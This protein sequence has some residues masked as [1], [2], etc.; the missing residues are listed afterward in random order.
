MQGDRLTWGATCQTIQTADSLQYSNSQAKRASREVAV[1]ESSDPRLPRSGLQ[2]KPGL[3][4]R[5]SSERAQVRDSDSSCVQGSRLED[6]P[7]PDRSSGAPD[8]EA[9]QAPS[10]AAEE[11]LS[12]LLLTHEYFR[13]ELLKSRVEELLKKVR[14]TLLPLVQAALDEHLAYLELKL[15]AGSERSDGGRGCLQVLALWSRQQHPEAVEACDFVLL[16]ADDA[17]ARL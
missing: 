10:E 7:D 9:S 12:G 4:P 14:E 1:E 13:K 5:R 6:R 15:A 16:E 2:P 11:D 17:F 8:P 3:G